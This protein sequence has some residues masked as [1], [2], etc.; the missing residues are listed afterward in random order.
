MLVEFRAELLSVSL[1]VMRAAFFMTNS[2]F[3]AMAYRALPSEPH[4]LGCSRKR[5]GRKN[6]Q[7][8][9]FHGPTARGDSHGELFAEGNDLDHD[10]VETENHH[11][12]KLPGEERHY[13]K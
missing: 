13:K 11:E 10:G 7:K 2:Q 5:G 8:K 6:V 3:L 12:D 4:G 1:L 9:R